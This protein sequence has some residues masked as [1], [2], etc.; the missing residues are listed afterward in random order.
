MTSAGSFLTWPRPVP[1]LT[2][3]AHCP[4]RPRVASPGLGLG[5]QL[6]AGCALLVPEAEVVFVSGQLISCAGHHTVNGRS[7]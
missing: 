4:K 1:T 5:P 6:P 2:P 7:L 3:H